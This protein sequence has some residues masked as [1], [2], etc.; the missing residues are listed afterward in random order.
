MRH[1]APRKPSRMGTT[2]RT[3]AVSALALGSLTVAAG[4]Q[5]HAAAATSHSATDDDSTRVQKQ[6]ADVIAAAAKEKGS[7]ITLSPEAA[8][9]LKAK[10]AAAAKGQTSRPVTDPAA[11]RTL[12][13]KVIAM[14]HAP[15]G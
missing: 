8:K 12:K 1:A 14:A 3:A 5:V 4:S 13:M 15:K 9:V 2:F 11:V 10:K 6:K 7:R